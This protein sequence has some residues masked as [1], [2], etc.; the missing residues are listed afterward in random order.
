[1]SVV[2]PTF[3]R[4]AL[5]RE[6]LESVARQ[7]YT[8]F[9]A[10]VV[11]DGSTDETREV[12][13]ASAVEPVYIYQ[14]NQG[15]G[16]A[17]NAGVRCARGELVAFLDSD[18]LWYPDRLARHVEFLARHRD[19]VFI[20]GPVDVIDEGGRPDPA[21]GRRMARLYRKA[22][23]R[24]FGL[25]TLLDSCLIFT[26]AV[27]ARKSLFD[28]VGLFDPDF[29]VREDFEWYLRAACRHRIDYLEGPPATAYRIHAGNAFHVGD[30]VVLEEYERVFSR[31]LYRT[32][33]N[34]LSSAARAQANISLSFCYAGLGDGERVRRHIRNAL[35]LRPVS[36]ARVDVLKRF[37]RSFLSN[38]ASGR[39]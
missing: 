16:A 38:R 2:V 27:T 12:V 26:S 19:A 36:L 33:E 4:A 7:T 37:A 14:E 10:I 1:M 9:E 32:P 28:E 6:A 13:A 8:N 34:G 25:E 39:G 20:H 35:R 22:A 3:N 11:D 18:D 29:R 24:G 15:R 5:L 17:R 31:Y 23:G 30:K 21:A